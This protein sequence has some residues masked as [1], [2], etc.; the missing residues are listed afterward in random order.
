MAAGDA[1]Y[2]MDAQGLAWR[3]ERGGKAVMRAPESLPRE[4]R[5]PV[6]RR[7]QA[8]YHAHRA[9]YRKRYGIES[10]FGAW[11]GL[12]G[13]RCPERK[14]EMA[15][16]AVWGRFLLWNIGMLYVWFLFWAAAG[17]YRMRHGRDRA[18]FFEHP[19]LSCTNA[20]Q[21]M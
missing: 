2:G 14:D 3:Y 4:V 11:K 8:D 21:G 9:A 10:F 13:S 6:R 17:G 1:R 18:V 19:H 12:C 16:G 20:L 5:R 15:F 7:A